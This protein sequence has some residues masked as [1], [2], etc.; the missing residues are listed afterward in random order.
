MLLSY[1]DCGRPVLLSESTGLAAT[2]K[3]AEVYIPPRRGLFRAPRSRL[4]QCVRHRGERAVQVAAQRLHGG[5]NHDGNAR[6]D[7]AVLD[8]RRTRLILVE[9]IEKLKHVALLM[10]RYVAVHA[11][12][13]RGHC[14]PCKRRR[15]K[16]N[17]LVGRKSF[18]RL[19][20][21]SRKQTRANFA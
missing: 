1:S 12:T 15:D 4:L 8:R 18:F 11:E 20:L 17:Y 5:N 3:D 7:Q 21:S 10:T 13:S 6:R 14:N 9:T 16:F 19:A 2:K